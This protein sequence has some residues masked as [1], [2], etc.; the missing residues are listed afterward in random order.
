[1]QACLQQVSVFIQLQACREAGCLERLWVDEMVW[2]AGYNPCMNG[3]DWK[4]HW[5]L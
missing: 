5:T 2:S 4:G 1:M 3:A